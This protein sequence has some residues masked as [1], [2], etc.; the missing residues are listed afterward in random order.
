MVNSFQP[1]W[2]MPFQGFN[3]FQ[4]F[5]TFP[6][7]QFGFG[8]WNTAPQ[9][10]NSDNESISIG[11]IDDLYKKIKENHAKT[12][13]LNNKLEETQ[14]VQEEAAAIVKKADNGKVDEL[15]GQIMTSET[16]DNFK[17]LSGWQKFKRGLLK[18]GEGVLN[19]GMDMLGI[20]SVIPP[21]INAKKALKAVAGIALVA[22]ASAI[23][24]VGPFVVPALLAAGAVCGGGKLAT[25]VYKACTTDDP[26]EFDEACQ[27][28]GEGA[29]IFGLS[30]AGIRKA[31]VPNTKTLGIKNNSLSAEK[32]SFKYFKDIGRGFKQM[33]TNAKTESIKGFK[34][35][36][37]TFKNTLSNTKQSIQNLFS[38]NAKN[39]KF[40]YGYRNNMEVIKSRI[41]EIDARLKTTGIT[42]AEKA[43]LEQ[44]KSILELQKL[45]INLTQT[46]GEWQVIKENSETAKEIKKLS[47]LESELTQGKKVKIGSFELKPTEENKTLL[48]GLIERNKKLSENVIEL[49][50]LREKTIKQMAVRKQNENSA[51]RLETYT[52]ETSRLK[53]LYNI[54][55]PSTKLTWKSA[56][57]SPFK[58][59]RKYFEISM[60]PYKKYMEMS[61]KG[62]TPIY[63]AER[64]FNP[65]YEQESILTG[66]AGLV[67]LQLPDWLGG[68]RGLTTTV[69]V[70]DENGQEVTQEVAITK[71]N[72]DELKKQKEEL[73]KE[74]NKIKEDIAKLNGMTSGLSFA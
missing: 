74:I 33:F 66:I 16:K 12:E 20:E 17:K 59:I 73:D 45:E 72:L 32:E 23:P 57:K 52:G 67:G 42:D 25:G 50:K 18:A 63:N 47:E 22:A 30:V 21:K 68:S 8:G 41:G 39:K 24:G 37:K 43:I 35:P 51:S 9:S 1:N 53:Q 40:G 44:E 6:T 70:Q 27:S 7:T 34:A 55:K 13:E 69:T 11:S 64:T 29:T 14:K 46:K 38:A 19:C 3:N 36:I 4:N 62:Y 31:G 56:L 60:L 26:K 48:K 49:A 54:Y 28:A 2:Q 71:D 65:T 5:N 15:T 58:A 61:K 10:S